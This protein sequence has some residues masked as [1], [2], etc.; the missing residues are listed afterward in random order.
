[1]AKVSVTPGRA[2]PVQLTLSLSNLSEQPLSAKEVSIDLSNPD[3][4]IEPITKTAVLA[5]DGSWHVDGLTLP[6]AGTWHI[7]VNALITDFNEA[8]LEGSLV[9]RR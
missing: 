7:T 5:A 3:A 8:N 1:M 6:V 2:G 9:I 4:G